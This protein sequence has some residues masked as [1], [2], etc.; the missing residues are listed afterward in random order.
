MAHYIVMD[1]TTG[2]LFY[3]TRDLPVD[4]VIDGYAMRHHTLDEKLACRWGDEAVAKVY[5][6][7]YSETT[8]HDASAGYH[9]FRVDVDGSEAVPVVWDGQSQEM[10]DAVERY[11]VYVASFI[12]KDQEG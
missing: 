3:D 2:Y 10:I 12:C 5:G 7:T 8:R 9:V 4:H 6:R 1:A 11:C